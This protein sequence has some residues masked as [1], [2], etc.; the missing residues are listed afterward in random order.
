[1][2]TVPAMLSGGEFVMNAAATQRIGEGNLGA[3]NSG[4][5]GASDDSRIVDKLQEL[6]TV[7]EEGHGDIN[8]TVNSDGTETT[9]GG[10]AGTLGGTS[11]ATQIRDAVTEVISQERRL[12]GALRPA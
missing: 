4:V 10:R 8:I 11:L 2:D 12:G 9:E 6:I 1:V 3:L 7:S 5:G